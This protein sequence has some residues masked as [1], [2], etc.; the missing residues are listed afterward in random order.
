ML[1]MPPTMHILDLK[2]KRRSCS[3]LFSVCMGPCG[4][5]ARRWINERKEG[6]VMAKEEGESDYADDNCVNL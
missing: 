5:Q 3:A 1:H 2:G 4:S 6:Y